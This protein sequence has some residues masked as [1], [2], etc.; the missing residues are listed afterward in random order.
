MSF[1]LENPIAYAQFQLRGG[2]KSTLSIAGVYTA[3]LV[4]FIVLTIRLGDGRTN[5]VLNGWVTGVMIIEIVLLLL[6][7][8]SRISAAIRRDITQNILE[9]HQLMPVGGFNAIIGYLLGGGATALA[10]AAA[11]L[12]IGVGVASAAGI[13]LAHFLLGHCVLFITVGFIWL[14][15]AF[16]AFVMKG[17][18][19]ILIGVIIAI[20]ST[21]GQI[22]SMLPGLN[23]LAAPITSSSFM[24]MRTSLTFIP[25]T[26][27][28]SILAQGFIALVCFIGAARKYRRL[29][30]SAIPPMLGLA[31]VGGWVGIS[32]IGI[33]WFESFRGYSFWNHAD[34]ETM[35]TATII[36]TMVIAIIPLASGAWAS[37]EWHQRTWTGDVPSVR[38]PMPM[39]VLALL[40]M[41]MVVPL[42]WVLPVTDGGTSVT[43]TS[44][45]TGGSAGPTTITSASP[46]WAPPPVIDPPEARAM[47]ALSMNR[48][49]ATAIVTF[50][51]FI[52]F[53]NLLR[54][55]YLKV[56]SGKVIAGVWLV[57]TCFVP[58]IVGYSVSGGSIDDQTE[59]LGEIIVS[60]SPVGAI[61]QIWDAAQLDVRVGL[62]IQL[63]VAAIPVLLYRWALR[64]RTANAAMAV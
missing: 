64:G 27:G 62:I 61:I 63:L 53:G 49:I 5:S 60:I 20:T 3:A 33:A 29:Q 50:A 55:I 47:R 31:L 11:T 44:F 2:W 16:M 59:R 6:Y 25:W 15:A 13:N 36:S 58:L 54:W 35:V 30:D 17:G 56:S 24:S 18:M 23:V 46:V 34:V 48:M 19:G 26:I 7:G 14:I 38:R 28:I 57:L 10:M 8:T 52:G 22:F 9:S 37:A 42:S 4:G 21:N 1:I 12:L 32:C 51:F 45:T 41:V 39:V 40:A 43:L